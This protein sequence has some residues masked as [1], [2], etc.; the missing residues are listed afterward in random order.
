VLKR[1]LLPLARRSDEAWVD[2]SWERGLW[3][4]LLPLR[5]RRQLQAARRMQFG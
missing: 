3:E 1:D 5:T 2:W 4:D